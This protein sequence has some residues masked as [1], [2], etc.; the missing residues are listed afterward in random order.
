MNEKHLVPFFLDP[1]EI[2]VL[3]DTLLYSARQFKQGGREEKDIK[4]LRR[5]HND[6]ANI[7]C[8]KGTQ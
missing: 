2:Q 1:N 4:L 6:V 7:F 8:I 5:L 3:Q